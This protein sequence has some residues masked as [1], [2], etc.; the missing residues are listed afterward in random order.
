MTPV[1]PSP[2]RG[3]GKRRFGRDR[4]LPGFNSLNSFVSTTFNILEITRRG[5][6]GEPKEKA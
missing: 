5:D 1:R 2:P 6:L 4:E 3:D